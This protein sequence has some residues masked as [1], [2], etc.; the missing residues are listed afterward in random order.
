MGRRPSEMATFAAWTFIALIAFVVVFQFALVAGAPWG[1]R[2][3]RGRVSGPLPHA[4]RGVSAFSATLLVAFAVVVAGRAGIALPGT[5]LVA[6][7]FVWVVV[8][9]AVLGVV[10]NAATP[11][12]G[13][14]AL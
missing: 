13:E 12:R 1:H 2:T 6:P 10:A 7:W 8:G 11:S 9:Y 5:G 14:R 4:M 3:M